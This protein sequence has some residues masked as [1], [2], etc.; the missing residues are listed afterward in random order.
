MTYKLVYFELWKEV[1]DLM[2][3]REHLT[4]SGLLKLIIIKSLF[5]K[6][7]NSDLLNSFP[8]LEKKSCKVPAYSPSL[9]FM[10]N[11]WLTGFINADG[12][13]GLNVSQNSV[14]SKKKIR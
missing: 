8:E 10:N 7:L 11:A 9:H 12:T 13:F 2:G 5:K 6:G 1:L 4:E 3:K 14:N